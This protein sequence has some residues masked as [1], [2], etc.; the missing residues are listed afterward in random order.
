VTAT[1][2]GASRTDVGADKNTVTGYEIKF[3]GS[4]V[5]ADSFKEIVLVAG[6]FEVT[7]RKITVK[8]VDESKVYDG[9]DLKADKVELT[10][11]SLAGG[12]ELDIDEATFTGAHKDVG[13]YYDSK[14]SGVRVLNSDDEDK[15]SNYEITFDAGKLEITAA[16]ITV[17]AGDDCEEG[18]EDEDGRPYDVIVKGYKGTYDGDEHTISVKLTNGE[19]SLETEP[20]TYVNVTNGTKE[21]CVTIISGGNYNELEVCANVVIDQRELTI[22]ADSKTYTYNGEEHTVEDYKI[23]GDGLVSG[24]KLNGLVDLPKEIDAGTYPIENAVKDLTVTK[25][26]DD[27]STENYKITVVDGELVIDRAT[28]NYCEGDD[29]DEED[30]DGN[31]YDVIIYGY[32]GKYDGKPHTITVKIRD[33]DQLSY[34]PELTTYTDVTGEPQEVCVT[35]SGDNYESFE[36]C[37]TVN[38]LPKKVTIKVDNQG[39]LVGENDPEFTAVVTGEIEGEEGTIVYSLVRELGEEVGEYKINVKDIC[40]KI[41]GNYIVA[42][43]SATFTIAMMVVPEIPSVTPP[44]TPEVPSAV[45]TRRTYSSTAATEEPEVLGETTE[46][47]VEKKAE[48]LAATDGDE[49]DEGAAWALLNL[50]LTIATALASVVLIVLFFVKKSDRE[51]E[52]TKRE[53]ASRKGV[54]RVLSLVPAIG[55]I[56]AFI[57][58]ENMSNPM[59]FVDRWTLLMVLIALV[60]VVIVYFSKKK[61]NYE[62][63]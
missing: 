6:E 45:T 10:G 63:K 4:I 26:N 1:T 16:T 2:S 34:S 51:D 30:E 25:A 56:V 31:P 60:Q 48:V 52:E 37:A 33:E 59:Q 17:C 36:R 11:G 5:D 46:E 41:V 44:T 49:E 42:C 47:E 55:A 53:V 39:K 7:P 29:C 32:E 21:V 43:E 35:I 62:D 15:T 20:E 8:P 13:V 38:I 61:Y 9:A 57:L 28:I 27:D 23:G 54:M 18:D 19:L 40:G 3:N 50:I 12:H 22:E 14:V 58:T 24:E